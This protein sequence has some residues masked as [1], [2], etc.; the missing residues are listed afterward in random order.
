M[1]L[2]DEAIEYAARLSQL[3][4]RFRV[5][6]GNR[7]ILI[8]SWMR[9]SSDTQHHEGTAVDVLL[10]PG[11]TERQVFTVSQQLANA[12]VRWGQ[13]IFYPY[14]P[15]RHW[16]LSLPTGLARN[17]VLVQIRDTAG[18]AHDTTAYKHLTAEL[19]AQFPTSPATP[20]DAFSLPSSPAAA[21]MGS[22]LLAL[23][24][25]LALGG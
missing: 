21:G 4:Q 15:A 16:H 12:G 22:V 1:P 20:G 8:T 11:V 9:S 13:L 17:D 5:A 6:L 24:I 14:T 2:T 7:P 3:L 10:P 23:G 18:D 19:L 25:A